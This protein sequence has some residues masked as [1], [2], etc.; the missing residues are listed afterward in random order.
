MDL[1]D[2]Y[3]YLAKNHFVIYWTRIPE[4]R[5]WEFTAYLK[6]GDTKPVEKWYFTEEFLYEMEL[7]RVLDDRK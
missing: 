1:N 4:K 6:E 7:R 5:M 2:F 3:L